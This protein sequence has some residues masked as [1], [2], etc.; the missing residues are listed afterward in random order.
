MIS[1]I[2][3]RT[4][5]IVAVC[6]LLGCTQPVDKNDLAQIHTIG[7]ASS[8]GQQFTRES[9]GLII[10]S[11]EVTTGDIADWGLDDEI[12]A[13]VKASLGSRFTV[14][15]ANFD[16]AKL[17]ADPGMLTLPQTRDKDALHRQDDIDAYLVFAPLTMGQGWD[18]MTGVGL[19]S[20]GRGET[21]HVICTARLLDRTGDRV[22]GYNLIKGLRPPGPGMRLDRWS[23]Y[24]P[25]Q[26]HQ[27]RWVA[28][29]VIGSAVPTALQDMNLRPGS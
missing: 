15:K 4:C 20:R 19:H 26:K 14:R 24:S 28:R 22:L 21:L 2:F 16:V 27:L 5:L 11:N 13:R 18:V 3:S 17:A 7:V 6:A 25:A 10:F 29:D 9:L 8:C 12:V 23:D 1:F